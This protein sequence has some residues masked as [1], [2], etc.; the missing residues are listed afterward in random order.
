MVPLS[1]A[2]EDLRAGKQRGLG[3]DV[4][5][6]FGHHASG[7]PHL[8]PSEIVDRQDR[9]LG[10]DDVRTMVDM[11]DIEHVV[12]GE[13]L[14]RDLPAAEREIEDIPFVGIAKAERI[15]AQEHRCRDTAGPVERERVHG[16]DHTVLDGVEQLEVADDVL[17]AEGLKGEFAAGLL[18]DR[19][20]PVLEDVET[21][22]AGPRGLDAP[23]RR[24]GC[25]R[26]ADVGCGEPT[27][28]RCGGACGKDAMPEKPAAS[29][30]NTFLDSLLSCWGG[31]HGSVLPVRLKHRSPNTAR[32]FRKTTVS[33]PGRSVVF[34]PPDSYPAGTSDVN[35]HRPWMPA[36]SA[37][38]HHR[39]SP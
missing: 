4:L 39:F 16:L 24:L 30:C 11:A 2:G 36:T 18:D 17:G 32:I 20:A 26:I 22:A 35:G 37:R 33:K 28:A 31:F 34:P 15:G 27:G 12:P 13:D 23:G 7:K 5:E 8:A 19:A 6:D 29:L 1:R 38:A 9:N 14:P 10:V 25:A 21:D 3:A